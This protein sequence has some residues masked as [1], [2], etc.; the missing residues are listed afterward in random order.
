MQRLRDAP[1]ARAPAPAL[2]PQK[3]A[4]DSHQHA[5]DLSVRGHDIQRL[6]DLLGIRSSADIAEVGRLSARIRYDVERAHHEP[7]A[8]PKY[9][10][11]PLELDVLQACLQRPLLLGVGRLHVVQ[12]GY[13]LMAK[14]AR[15]VHR[16]L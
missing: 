3:P 13:V 12:R 15:V 6:R 8:V 1:G 7:R 5:L 4:Q 14:E 2:T 10:D 11:V 16:Y 9:P